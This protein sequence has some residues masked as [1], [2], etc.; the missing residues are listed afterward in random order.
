[1]VVFCFKIS[2][3]HIICEIVFKVSVSP[4][5]LMRVFVVWTYC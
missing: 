3:Q 1:M 4:H 5:L 2:V